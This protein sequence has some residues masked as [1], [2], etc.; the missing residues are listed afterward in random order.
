MPRHPARF[1]CE[2]IDLDDAADDMRG[3][4]GPDLGGR[5]AH[6]VEKGL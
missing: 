4:D 1:H 6:S 2:R 3:V 5:G